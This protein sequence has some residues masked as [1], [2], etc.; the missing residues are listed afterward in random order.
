MVSDY[1]WDGV[2]KLILVNWFEDPVK[3]ACA[4]GL[5]IPLPDVNNRDPAYWAAF[6]KL[7]WRES[8]NGRVEMSPEAI[9]RM[10]LDWVMLKALTPRI[11]MWFDVEE[12]IVFRCSARV[13]SDLVA[14]LR[15]TAVEHGLD[16][17]GHER[18]SVWAIPCVSS[19]DEQELDALLTEAGF[20]WDRIHWRL[21]E[22]RVASHEA[23]DKI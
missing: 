3:I 8:L 23:G 17:S 22:A 11:A 10:D 2:T 7:A 12:G 15:A 1:H 21:D 14:I 20:I 13:V 4:F 19:S 6:D 5:D 16:L 9:D 18:G